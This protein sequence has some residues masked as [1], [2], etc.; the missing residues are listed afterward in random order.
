MERAFMQGQTKRVKSTNPL[1]NKYFGANKCSFKR[2][3]RKRAIISTTLLYTYTKNHTGYQMLKTEIS[4]NRAY[5]GV[6]V[7]FYKDL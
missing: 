2:S 6:Y 1:T 3:P 5:R 4:T 7:L